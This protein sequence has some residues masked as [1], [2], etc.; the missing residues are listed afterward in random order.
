M[1]ASA[2]PPILTRAESE[3]M[4]RFW[5]VGPLTILELQSHLPGR[6]YTSLATLVKI[7]ETKG[8]LRHAQTEGARAF[9]YQAAIPPDAARRHHARDL[10]DRLFGGKPQELVAGLLSDEKLSRRELERLR[11][12]IDARLARGSKR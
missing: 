6:A 12:E 10:V 9:V 4:A 2:K 7:L 1:I 11:A 8:Y 3:I 5:D